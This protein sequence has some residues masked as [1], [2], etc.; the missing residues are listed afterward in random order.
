[1]NTMQLK[2]VLPAWRLGDAIGHRRLVL[3]PLYGGQSRFKEYL[4]ASEAMAMGMLAIS[5]VGEAGVVPELQA[6]NRGD[7][8]I[9]LIDGEELQG[10]KQN[11]I[12]NTTIL[13]RPH[14][15][16]KIPVSC[17][18]QGRWS[19]ANV[20]FSSGAYAPSSIRQRKCQ[21]VHASI[22]STGR[23]TSDQQAIWREVEE[24]V[25]RACPVSPTRSMSDTHRS[26]A[27]ELAQYQEALPWPED[28]CG[29]VAAVH[30]AFLALDVF[31]SPQ[32]MQMVWPRL[33][34]SYAIDAE[35]GTRK[36][37][38]KFSSKA[39]A[40]LLEHLAE[41]T[42]EAFES[43]GLGMDLRFRSPSLIGQGLLVDRNLL[44]MSV[45]PPPTERQHAG[46]PAPR[47]R[48]PSQRTH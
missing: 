29:V 47:I 15:V 21:D 25:A 44:H 37:G 45:F 43:V 32:A 41:Q 30:R 38:A 19:K 22:R 39:A 12:L 26:M 3:V 28:A 4:L 5:E 18:E 40:I 13:L 20:N 46:Q 35:A 23:A 7:H 24:H 2:D 10:A 31:D 33:I 6:E 17:V 27:G 11:R 1:M 34:A 14:T 36:P 16:C 9:L 8:P 48:P 42:T